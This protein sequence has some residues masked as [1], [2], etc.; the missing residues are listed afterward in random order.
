MRL[1]II[2]ALCSLAPGLSWAQTISPGK[3]RLEEFKYV[4]RAAFDPDGTGLAVT[5]YRDNAVS[6]IMQFTWQVQSGRLLQTDIKYTKDRVKWLA[7]DDAAAEIRNITV[8]SFEV[9]RKDGWVK[10]VRE[11]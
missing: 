9:K 8:T 2:I 5:E 7:A 11:Q 1:S 6:L 4:Q 10:W 3:Y